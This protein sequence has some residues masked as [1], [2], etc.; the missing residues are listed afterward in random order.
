[1]K[2]EC[3]VN[4]PMAAHPIDVPSPDNPSDKWGPDLCN[5]YFGLCQRWQL[6]YDLSGALSLIDYIITCSHL[7]LLYITILPRIYKV[8]DIHLHQRHVTGHSHGHNANISI[9]KLTSLSSVNL[10]V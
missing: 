4:I 5:N 7:L 8:E 1:M 9:V 3:K 2:R 6:Q 10:V